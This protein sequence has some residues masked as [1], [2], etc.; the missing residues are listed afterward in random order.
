MGIKGFNP[1][2]DPIPETDVIK[3]SLL[4]STNLN[5]NCLE[6]HKINDEKIRS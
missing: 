4:N 1:S 3:I 6:T 5:I 2:D